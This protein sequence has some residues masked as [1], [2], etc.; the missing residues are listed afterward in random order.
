[1]RRFC[2]EG[3]LAS[4][5]AALIRLS[6]SLA[7]AAGQR[8]PKS[9]NQNSCVWIRC[10]RLLPMPAWKSRLLRVT[11]DLSRFHKPVLW[12]GRRDLNP[13]G[14]WPTDFKSGMST[15]SITPAFSRAT[16]ERTAVSWNP[17]ESYVNSFG[18]F[19]TCFC[20]V[21]IQTVDPPAKPYRKPGNPGAMGKTPHPNSRKF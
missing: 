4:Q 14:Q 20:I 3:V 1:M 12:C 18:G 6:K 5:T 17:S 2:Q 8:A 7:T 9:M 19:A 16:H 15:N 11:L 10:F 21:G 13:H